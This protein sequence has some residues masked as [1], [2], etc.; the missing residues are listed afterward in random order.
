MELEDEK[1]E[2]TSCGN[3]KATKNR[4]GTAYEDDER[5]WVVLCPRC[6]EMDDEYWREQ[7]EEYYNSVL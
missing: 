7:W 5:N 2:C 3:M 6:Q 1:L 4:R